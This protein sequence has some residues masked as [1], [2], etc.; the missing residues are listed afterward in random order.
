[1]AYSEEAGINSWNRTL[2]LNR[3]KNVIITDEIAM[4][5]A[6][7]LTQHL[8]TV[9]PSEIV[10]PGELA[11]HYKNERDEAEDFVVLFD[12][13]KWEVKVEKVKLEAPED[14]GVRQKWGDRVYR[15][16]FESKTPKEQDKMEFL[17]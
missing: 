8:M 4:D 6:D 9:Y 11:V 5:R 7:A 12:A 15:I 13:E 16:N 10:K 3:G 17:I 14:E 2:E 1:G